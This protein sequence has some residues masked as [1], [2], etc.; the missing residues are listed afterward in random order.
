M[1]VHCDAAVGVLDIAGRQIQRIDIGDA[2]GAVD[3]AIGFG[4]VF[5]AFVGN[6]PA[7]GR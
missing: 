5:D 1:T 3:D 4:D 2:P 6:S 7:A